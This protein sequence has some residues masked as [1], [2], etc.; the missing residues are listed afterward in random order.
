MDTELEYTI[1]EC[2]S[3][4]GVSIEVKRYSRAGWKPLGG[5]SIAVRLSGDRWYAQAMTRETPR[6]AQ[7]PVSKSRSL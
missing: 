2:F 4:H 5:V 1:V 7:E 3:P 6:A